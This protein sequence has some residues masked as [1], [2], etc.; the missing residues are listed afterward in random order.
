MQALFRSR[1]GILPRR[2]FEKAAIKMLN[3]LIRERN[4]M[5]EKMIDIEGFG[6][7]SEE[8]IK[9]ALAEKFIGRDK[10]IKTPEPYQF[11]AGDVAKDERNSKRIIVKMPE[12]IMPLEGKLVSFYTDGI[13]REIGQ[14]AFENEDYKLIGKLSDYIK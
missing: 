2:Y 13:W 7:V 1:M 11:Q 14:E 9:T 8:T 4:K 5:S 6:K 3:R 10:I 12:D